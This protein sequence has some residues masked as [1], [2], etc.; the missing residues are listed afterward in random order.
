M[1]AQSPVLFE[2]SEKVIRPGDSLLLRWSAKGQGALRLEPGGLKLEETGQLTLRPAGTTLY[3]LKRGLDGRMLGAVLVRVDAAQPM[4]EPARVCAFDA[5]AKAVLP[6]DPVV[7]TWE[8]AGAAKVRLEPGGLELD[9]Q[10]SVVV[11]PTEN[12]RYTLSVSNAAGGQSRSIDVAVRSTPGDGAPAAIADFRAEPAE[13][14]EGQAVTLRW[15][16]P[17]GVILKLEPMG[18]DLTGRNELVVLPSRTLVY[19]L[20]ASGLAGGTSRSVEVKVRSPRA[21]SAKVDSSLLSLLEAA[22]LA[23][24]QA[25]S[26]ARPQG[27]WTLRLLSTVPAEGLRTLARQFKDGS[28]TLRVLPCT[29]KGAIRGWQACWGAFPTRAAALAAWERAPQRLRKLYTPMVVRRG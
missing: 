28:G 9:G 12:T 15:T 13:V 21:A 4:G 2:A 22:D 1:S 7:L 23:A 19:T 26:E 10:S 25:W 24:A 3:L 18:L 14:D 29:L 8:C 17:S 16:C 6:G 20:S 5:S 11:A 27:P